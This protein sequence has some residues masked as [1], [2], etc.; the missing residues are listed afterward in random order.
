MFGAVSLPFNGSALQ[1]E[2]GGVKSERHEIWG[3]ISRE[4]GGLRNDG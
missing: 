3:I 4:K 2:K 1:K